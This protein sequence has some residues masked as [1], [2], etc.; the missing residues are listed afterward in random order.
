[1]K[2]GVE[3]ISVAVLYKPSSLKLVQLTGTDTQA[4]TA[5]R[6]HKSTFIFNLLC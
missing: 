5:W 3:M 1:M 2:Y 6:S 4:Q